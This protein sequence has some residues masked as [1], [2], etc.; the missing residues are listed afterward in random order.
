[1]AFSSNWIIIVISQLK[2]ITVQQ[3]LQAFIDGV[4][5]VTDSGKKVWL[6]AQGILKKLGLSPRNASKFLDRHVSADFKQQISLKRA[7]RPSW[8]VSEEGAY[9]L[10]MQASTLEAIA[11]Q[12]WVFEEVLPTIRKQGGYISPDASKE[13]LEGL[14]TQIE[15]QINSLN[16][17]F[18]MAEKTND[19]RLKVTVKSIM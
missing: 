11:L 13:Q 14:Q 3:S 10:G 12:R 17:A 18:D 19:H 5:V 2:V 9:Q 6:S 16:T 4:E 15:T 7:G 8:Y 1:M